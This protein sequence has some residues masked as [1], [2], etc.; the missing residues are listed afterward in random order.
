[1]LANWRAKDLSIRVSPRIQDL[2]A[3]GPEEDRAKIPA[4]YDLMLKREE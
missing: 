4:D 3:A 2:E 1:M